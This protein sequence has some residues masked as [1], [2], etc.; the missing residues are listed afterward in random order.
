MGY[1]SEVK[2]VAGKN[3]AIA[4]REVLK[5]FEDICQL[6]EIGTNERGDTLFSA[7]WAK[8]YEDEEDE[9]PDV[10]AVMG[11]VNKFAYDLTSDAKTP[12][13]GIE[14][15]RVGEDDSDTDYISN[16][17]GYGY[18]SIGV[19]CS[20]EDKFKDTTKQLEAVQTAL[21]L[22]EELKS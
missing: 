12:E 8:W 22:D 21:K 3:P 2:I 20:G 4:L 16:G 11:V 5:K 19:K 18:L 1:R 14:Y 15:A 9:F 17:C 6:S 10:A 7:D 13:N